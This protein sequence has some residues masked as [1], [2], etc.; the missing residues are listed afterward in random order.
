MGILHRVIC[1]ISCHFAVV[2]FYITLKKQLL[3]LTFSRN[4][5]KRFCTDRH[6]IYCCEG[7]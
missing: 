3:A 6:I 7:K 1:L 2:F 4:E 5:R